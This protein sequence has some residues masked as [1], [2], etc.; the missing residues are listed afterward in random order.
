MDT[1]RRGKRNQRTF[2]LLV[3][4]LRAQIL[5]FDLTQQKI[6]EDLF[7]ECCSK[8]YLSQDMVWE[9]ASIATPSMLNKLFKVSHQ[10]ANFVVQVRDNRAGGA[11]ISVWTENPPTALLVQNLPKTWSVRTKDNVAR[12]QAAKK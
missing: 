10:Y 7:H 4:V 9:I 3:K 8:G 2:V 1:F 12:P 11:V 5:A 6:V